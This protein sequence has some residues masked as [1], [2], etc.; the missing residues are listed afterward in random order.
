MIQA[1]LGTLARELLKPRSATPLFVIVVAMIGGV[2]NVKM[3]VEQGVRL[4]LWAAESIGH[5]IVAL[6]IVLA[7]AAVL[8]GMRRRNILFYACVEIP[9]AVAGIW[10]TLG[11]QPTSSGTGS[12][13]ALLASVYVLIRGVGNVQIFVDQAGKTQ[14]AQ[15]S[16]LGAE[17]RLMPVTAKSD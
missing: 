3:I 6:L 16:Q 4:H 1:K 15:H 12:G 11:A 5:R 8:I 14:V 2:S 7:V 17:E 10:L 13:L 9:A